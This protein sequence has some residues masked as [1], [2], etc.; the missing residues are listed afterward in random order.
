MLK[1]YSFPGTISLAVHIALEEA[2]AEYELVKV[3]FL[4]DEQRSPEYLALN[5]KSRVPALATGELLSPELQRQRLRTAPEPGGPADFGYG[6][7]IF[8]VAGWLGHNGSVPGYQTVAVYLPERKITLVTMINTDIAV[9]GQVD[10]SEALSTAIT[11]V[12]T[13]D[14]VYRL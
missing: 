1:L 12:L 10:P 11:S 8:E 13:P 5:P 4:K 6:I 9:P 3:D 2:G 14:H 7:G